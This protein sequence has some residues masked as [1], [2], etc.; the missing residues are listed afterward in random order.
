MADCLVR[1]KGMADSDCP[2]IPVAL[3]GMV[4]TPKSF[5]IPAATV[6]DGQEAVLTYLNAQVLLGNVD[7][8]PEFQSLEDISQE[9]VYQ[10][11]IFSITPV[12]DGNYR[13]R[14]SIAKSLC[15]HKAMFTHRTK[16]GRVFMIDDDGWWIGTKKTNGDFAGWD[17]DLLHTEKMKFNNGTEASFT[18]L[19]VAFK[20]NKEWDRYGMMVDLSQINAEIYRMVDV[21]LSIP[22]GSPAIT[23]SA[24]TI[25]VHTECDD[26]PVEGLVVA[27]FVALDSA[28]DVIALTTAVENPNIPGRYLISSAAAFE[29]DMTIDIDTP[30]LLTLKPYQNSEATGVV[31]TVP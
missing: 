5:V 28:G 11:T 1:K 16:N 21:V 19:M 30:T 2:E 22:V 27:D 23:A 24:L 13:F 20:N 12:K 8:F 6:A 18:P 9:A 17:L 14:P 25:Q 7:Y 31:I 29:D 10:D 3:K 15:Q 26:T 4:K